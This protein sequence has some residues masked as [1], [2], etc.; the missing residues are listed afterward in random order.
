VPGKEKAFGQASVVGFN[1]GICE[2]SSDP[3]S[4]GGDIIVHSPLLKIA[5]MEWRL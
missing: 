5:L 4:R 3:L 1:G 2:P